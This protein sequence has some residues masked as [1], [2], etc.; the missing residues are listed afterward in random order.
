MKAGRFVVNLNVHDARP[1]V[2]TD[3]E[4]GLISEAAERTWGAV[5]RARSAQT[6]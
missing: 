6:R 5:E 2:W 3:D 4:I 1:R